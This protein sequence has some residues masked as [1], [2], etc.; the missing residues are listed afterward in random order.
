MQDQDYW[1][2]K[3]PLWETALGVIS[4]RSFPAIIDA[5]DV[6]LKASGVRLIGYEKVGSGY[7]SAIVRG[8][9]AEVRLAIQMGAEEAQRS[10]QL[11]STTLLP[12]PHPNMEFIFPFSSR[13]LGMLNGRDQ[14]HSSQALGFLET[15]GFPAMVGAA[16]AMLK[17]AN[18]ELLSYETIGSG[19]CTAII[20]GSVTNVAVAI[21]A[22]IA[23]ALRQK[24]ELNAVTVIP[25]PLDDLVK[26][27]P[28]VILEEEPQPL[29][30]PINVK[31]VEK[32]LVKIPLELSTA[33]PVELPIDLP[34]D[35]STNSPIDSST[36]LSTNSSAELPRELPNLAY[37]PT[38]P[39]IDPLEIKDSEN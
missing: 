13:L 24:W 18:V 30:L 15:R 11:I 38:P 7:V 32:E 35:S 25:R 29:R 16:D 33:S 14:R 12:R 23:E 5:A 1:R 2:N 37:L 27:L 10:G 34:I 36:D 28:N 17:S 22:G 8:K 26:T 21:E 6:M 31:E 3:D 4:T 9:I 20:Q 39:E 19:L